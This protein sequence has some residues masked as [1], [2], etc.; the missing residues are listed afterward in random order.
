MF[1][2]LLFSPITAFFPSLQK[3]SRP[4]PWVRLSQSLVWSLLFQ[5]AGSTQ[6]HRISLGLFHFTIFRIYHSTLVIS[7]ERHYCFDISSL[8]LGCLT[9]KLYGKLCQLGHLSPLFS[10]SN[11][12]IFPPSLHRPISCLIFPFLRGIQCIV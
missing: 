12:V 8:L 3:L 5:D 7:F 2:F 9:A 6:I 11:N 1:F 4:S 10:I